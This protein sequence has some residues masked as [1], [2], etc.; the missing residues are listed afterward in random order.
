MDIVIG[1]KLNES[2]NGVSKTGSSEKA[3]FPVRLR[4]F[5]VATSGN[6]RS[7]T[8]FFSRSLVR[9]TEQHSIDE[10]KRLEANVLLAFGLIV[11][12]YE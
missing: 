5:R 1:N 7:Q 2:I 11:S 12:K 4:L 3:R 8:Y 10:L 6:T 9:N